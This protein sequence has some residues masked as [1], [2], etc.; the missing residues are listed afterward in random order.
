MLFNA[1]LRENLLLARPWATQA[2]LETAC[3]QAELHDF[4]A[5][6]PEGYDTHVGERGLSLSG[7]ERQRLAIARALLK[8]APILLLDEP[9]ANLDPATEAKIITTLH[10]LLSESI[11]DP[12]PS[13]YPS[14]QS[15]P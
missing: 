7:G 2:D 5:S 12:F 6:L 14:P 13:V 4:I 10:R 1:S 11:R 8:D 3:Q 9:T 15:V